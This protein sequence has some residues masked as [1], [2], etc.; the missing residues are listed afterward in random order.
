VLASA[1]ADDAAS[2]FRSAAAKAGIEYP[3]IQG[4]ANIV[5]APSGS[6]VEA[7]HLPRHD[8]ALRYLMKNRYTIA[9][10][11]KDGAWL[12]QPTTIDM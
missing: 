9:L 5:A 1:F 11:R 2:D 12:I 4:R 3:V 8:Q 7:A 10:V 6:L